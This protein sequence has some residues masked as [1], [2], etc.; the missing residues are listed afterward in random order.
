MGVIDG[1]PSKM[2]HKTQNDVEGT[3][4]SVVRICICRLGCRGDVVVTDFTLSHLWHY[5]N[6]H[7][8][9]TLV[10]VFAMQCKT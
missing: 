6:L 9:G 4:A 7:K 1:V 8:T 2:C 3:N 5:S 10:L